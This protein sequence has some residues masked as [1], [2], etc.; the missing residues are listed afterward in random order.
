MI[1]IPRWLLFLVATWVLAFG[2]FRLF[3][4]RQRRRAQKEPDSDR[5]N[6]RRKGFY[7]QSPRRHLA[8]GVLY[9]L[10][11]GVLVAMGFGWQPP[12]LGSGCDRG[13]D[14]GKGAPSSTIGV[15]RSE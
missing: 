12:V 1:T 10:M 6:F 13:A 15:D 5:P 2:T 14:G 8:F 3:V 11:G 7:A 9:L 4:A